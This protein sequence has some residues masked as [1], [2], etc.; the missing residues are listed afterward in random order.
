MPVIKYIRL[1]FYFDAEQLQK[2]VN[3][4][5]AQHWQLH[6]QTKHYTGGWSA[7]PLRS[8][9]GN[10]EN[11]IVSPFDDVVYK[12]TIFLEQSV[13]LKE[14]LS[15]FPCLLKAVRLL[16]LDAGAIIKEHR[17][18]E[19]AFEHGEVR[20]HIP[21]ITNGL[22]EFILDKE[23]MVLKEGECWYM[24]FNL[25]HTIENKSNAAR[26]HLVIDAVV[27]DWVKEL[28]AQ[29]SLL[30]K[31]TEEPGL[32]DATRLQIIAQLRQLGTDTGNRLADEMEM[33][34]A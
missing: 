33:S 4:I 32:D 11:I 7:I 34:K 19:L 8:V 10:T 18:A 1:P 31:E 16:K 6:Y 24:N 14:V 15:S 23:R 28:F 17:D 13:Y 27:N 3:S 25:L 2:E 26:I 9:G 20:I 21:V 30:R 5:A 12:D 22:V 29:P